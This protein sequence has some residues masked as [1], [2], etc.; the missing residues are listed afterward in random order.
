MIDHYTEEQLKERDFLFVSYSHKEEELVHKSVNHL[1][2]EGVQIWYDVDIHGGDDWR[3]VA[4][5]VLKSPHCV[6]VIFFN[7]IHS[8]LSDQVADERR[9]YKQKQQDLAKSEKKFPIFFVN[10]GKPSTMR[11]IKQIFDN[12][13]DNDEEIFK[14]FRT[15][16]LVD[17]LDLFKDS[18][19][20]RYADPDN[21][22]AF[23]SKLYND[24]S[25]R[26]SQAIDKGC[27]VLDKI[28]DIVG[29]EKIWFLN[30]GKWNLNGESVN[31]K[32][33]FLRHEQNNGIFLSENIL[34]E[35]FG[36]E[37]LQKRLNN[38]FIKTIFS[39]NQLNLLSQ[40]LRLLSTAEISSLPES[41]MVRN[42]D[43]WLS[44]VRGNLQ[45]IVRDDGSVYSY[46]Y[47]NKNNECGVRPVLVLPMEYALKLKSE[48]T[49]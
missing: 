33:R 28:E 13:P 1:L 44:D 6:G 29:K 46:G 17:I 3:D 26:M 14:R 24:I 49:Y 16:K 48:Q 35:S 41:V 39:E 9:W 34:F 2:N 37:S 45:T 36:G 42:Y 32:W 7:S 19:I 12:L 30:F 4:E 31:I 15:E 22:E 38:H 25:S 40:P 11:L 8:F 10:I 21:P 20:Y 27:V 5:R 43:W 18:T 23:L 47:N